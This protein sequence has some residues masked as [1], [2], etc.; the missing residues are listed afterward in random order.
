MKDCA[1]LYSLDI[2][3]IAP[4]SET[5]YLTESQHNKLISRFDKVVL[6]FDTDTTGLKFLNKCRKQHPELYPC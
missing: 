1:L 5:V 3:A 2:P 4:N 6:L